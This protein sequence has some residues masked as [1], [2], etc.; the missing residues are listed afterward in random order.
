MSET[1]SEETQTTN[2][3]VEND[4][5]DANNIT[6]TPSVAEST[7]TSTAES[8]TIAKTTRDDSAI[9]RTTQPPVPMKQRPQTVPANSLSRNFNLL[10]GIKEFLLCFNVLPKPKK[11]SF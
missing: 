5:V 10:C 1:A 8:T 2:V 7:E 3:D 11:T 4:V 6:D 9:E